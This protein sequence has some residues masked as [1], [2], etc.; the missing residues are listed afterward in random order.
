MRLRFQDFKMVGDYN[1]ALHRI[2]TSLRM[3]GVTITDTQKIE[4]TLSTFHLD[5]VQSSR[6]YRQGKY[7]QY[8]EL[9]DILQVEEA[10]DE[11]LR[12]NSLAQPLGAS[13]RQGAMLTSR[14]PMCL[15]RRRE[16]GRARRR[17]TP[18]AR[19]SS[20]SQARGSRGPRNAT[21]AALQNI[22]H[23]SAVHL[24]TLWKRTRLVR[25]CMNRTSPQYR[26]RYLRYPWWRPRSSRRLHLC[27]WL[28]L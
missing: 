18:L 13:S 2:C 10:Q 28:H 12:K 22:S 16:A 14:R 17:L 1:S 25:R 9:V 8:A 5:A 3:C 6:N 27:L 4:K 26:G 24:R 11:L 21:G 23:A 7:T 19:L 20:I 15:S